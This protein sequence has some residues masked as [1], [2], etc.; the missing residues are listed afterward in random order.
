MAVNE[1]ALEFLGALERAEEALLT[2]GV[3][4]CFFSDE[5]LEQR[6]ED[7]LEGLGTRGIVA[8]YDSV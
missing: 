5:E 6:A 7:F 2:W 1:H 3:V 8:G 4:D